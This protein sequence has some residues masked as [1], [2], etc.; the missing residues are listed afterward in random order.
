MIGGLYST[1][2]GRMYNAELGNLLLDLGHLTL[3]GSALTKSASSTNLLVKF[4]TP[5]PPQILED[6]LCREDVMARFAVSLL[7]GSFCALCP[8]IKDPLL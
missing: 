1:A 7:W 2:A 6:V 5:T 8:C 4:Q 3:T